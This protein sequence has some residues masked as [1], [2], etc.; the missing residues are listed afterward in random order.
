MPGQVT[1][2]VT[3]LNTEP[4]Q[5]RFTDHARCIVGRARDCDILLPSDGLHADVSRRHC[6]FEI[7]PPAVQV[8]D[9]GSRNGTYVNG[10][11]IGQRPRG[12]S[13][14][15]TDSGQSPAHE[16]KDGDEVL[17]GHAVIRV[18]IL[19]SSDVLQPMYFM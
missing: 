2:T 16:L 1:L 15:D 3:D 5:H 11:L 19:V 6:L 13:P 14:D 7:Y 4:T 8:R 17:V 12:E 9:L 10:E 18:A